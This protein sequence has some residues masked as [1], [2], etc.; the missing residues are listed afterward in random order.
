MK[1][2]LNSILSITFCFSLAAQKNPFLDREYWNGNPSV[3][4]IEATIS[5]GFDITERNAAYFDGPTYAILQKVNTKTMAHIIAKEGNGVDKLT[6]DGRIYLHWAAYAGNLELVKYLLYVGSNAAAVDAHGYSVLNFAAN[7]GVTDTQIFDALLEN[8][9]DIKA[10][11]HNGANALLL[12]SS[13]ADN[14]EVLQYF[15]DRGLPLNSTDDAG[16]GVFQYASRG[17]NIDLLKTLAKN[18][19]DYKTLNSEGENALFMAARGTRRIQN[20]KEVFDYLEAMGLSNQLVNKEGKNLLHLIAGRNKDLSL[21]AHYIESGVSPELKDEE[22]I[23]PF[24]LAASGNDLEVLDLLAKHVR[25]IN[26]TDEKGRNALM[27]AVERNSNTVVDF[28]L[29]HGANVN[30]KD[31]D[32]NSVAFYLIQN[33]NSQNTEEFDNK[34]NTLQEAGLS[35]NG[36]QGNG[37]TLLHLAAKANN[38]SLLKRLEPLNIDIDQK[39]S[40]GITALH[41]AAMS[42]DNEDMLKYLISRGADVRAKTEFEETVYDLASENELLQKHNVALDFFKI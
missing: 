38:L 10:T 9:A 5:Q 21:F 25:D 17:G 41:L 34:W 26:A 20:T 27:M 37:N 39:N 35:L 31:K 2:I 13:G 6:H 42:S 3:E 40:E 29:E 24:M 30:V 12:A 32:G 18:G 23:T 19:L 7:S 15:V 8:G 33:Y 16:N 22:G 14:F 4:E 36:K 11:T 28:L 1:N